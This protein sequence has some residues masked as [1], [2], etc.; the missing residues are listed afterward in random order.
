MLTFQLDT[1]EFRRLKSKSI[2]L[3]QN[4]TIRAVK[5]AG[6]EGADYARRNHR[7]KRRTGALTSPQNLFFELR[8]ADASEVWGYITNVT[9]YAAYVEY[10]TRPHPI[11]PKSGHGFKGPMRRG[12]SRRAITDIGTH[13]VAL[14]FESGGRIV[15]AR[16][17]NHPGS[18]PYIFMGPASTFAANVIIRETNNVTFQLISN[19]WD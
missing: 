8:R 11:W 7:H 1:S 16:M 5:V 3:L 15:F 4:G 18:R 12:Q 13:R 10:G 2:S 9:P 17:V 14:R 6:D 19:L